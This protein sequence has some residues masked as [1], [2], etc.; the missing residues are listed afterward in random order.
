[1]LD[2]GQ[3]EDHNYVESYSALTCSI[4]ARIVVNTGDVSTSVS[5]SS[6]WKLLP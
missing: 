1:V 3:T 4:S 2:W 6:D 5:C